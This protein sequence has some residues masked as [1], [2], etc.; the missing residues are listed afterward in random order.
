MG[1]DQHS[2]ITDSSIRAILG[3]SLVVQN[4]PS[5]AGHV[6]SIPG[7]ETKIPCATEQLSLQVATREKPAHP[8]KRPRMTQ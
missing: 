2:R 5:N 3:T 1:P 4:P 6:G 7:G 8:N